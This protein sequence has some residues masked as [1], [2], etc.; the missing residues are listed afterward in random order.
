MSGTDG[1]PQNYSV[2]KDGHGREVLTCRDDDEFFMVF[3]TVAQAVARARYYEGLPEMRERLYEGPRQALER[4]AEQ[5]APP[6]TY[7]AAFYDICAL[8]GVPAMPTPPLFAYLEVVRPR[9][10]ALLENKNGR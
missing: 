3:P 4:T 8:L 10:I 5:A 9:I 7:E 6:A 2:H 1:L